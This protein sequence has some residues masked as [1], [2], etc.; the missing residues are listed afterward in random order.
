MSETA[1]LGYIEIPPIEP[2]PE[3]RDFQRLSMS[4]DVHG[5]SVSQAL[6]MLG[7]ESGLT[8]KPL[9]CVHPSMFATACLIAKEMHGVVE[10]LAMR[11]IQDE[12]TWGDAWFVAWRGKRVGSE[13]A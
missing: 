5:S 2:V 4:C 9:L 10:P 12:G 13:G 11:G 7:W 6:A 1:T 3:E 8:P